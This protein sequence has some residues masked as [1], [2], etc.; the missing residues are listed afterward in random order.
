MDFS[1]PG[2][3]RTCDLRFRKPLEPSSGDHWR[4]LSPWI[5]RIVTGTDDWDREV[6][7]SACAQIVHVPHPTDRGSNYCPPSCRIGSAP[8]A[9]TCLQEPETADSQNRADSNYPTSSERIAVVAPRPSMTMNPFVSGVPSGAWA[10][11]CA[12]GVSLGC[13]CRRTGS[14]TRIDSCYRPEDVAGRA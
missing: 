4:R 5:L 13:T 1:A 3:T 8:I 9:I 14:G 12:E 11:Q 6:T 2:T 10:Y 7:G